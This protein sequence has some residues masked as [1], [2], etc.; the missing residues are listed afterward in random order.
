MMVTHNVLTVSLT[1]VLALV[2]CTSSNPLAGMEACSHLKK[3]RLTELCI[4]TN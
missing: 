2:C 1:P 4:I 3:K